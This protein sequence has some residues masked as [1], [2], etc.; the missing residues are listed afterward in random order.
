M[1]MIHSEAMFFEIMYLYAL[2]TD[3]V[4]LELDI[5]KEAFYELQDIITDNIKT[6]NYNFEVELDNLVTRY[7]SVFELTDDTLIIQSDIDQVYVLLDQQ[8]E[9]GFT[10]YDDHLTY[11]VQNIN[12]Y[13]ILDIKDPSAQYKPLWQLNKTILAYHFLLSQKENKGEK[14]NSKD[15]GILMIYENQFRDMIS[16]IS[17][18]DDLFIRAALEFQNEN[19]T[20]NPDWYIALFEDYP[21]QNKSFNHS[22]VAYYLEPYSILIKAEEKELPDNCYACYTDRDYFLSYFIIVLDR[23]LPKLYSNGEINKILNV[24]KHLLIAITPPLEKAYL[25]CGSLNGTLEPLA[26]GKNTKHAFLSFYPAVLERIQTLNSPDIMLDVNK[27]SNMILSAIFIR[28]FLDTCMHED[29]L[30]DVYH[31]IKDAKWFNNPN[32]YYATLFTQTI[33]LSGDEPDI[34]KKR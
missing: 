20:L 4:E 16:N 12:I 9:G 27:I 22:L 18:K 21:L 6:I 3:Y 30:Q 33:I 7:S 24:R 13:H 29:V 28:T 34:P 11:L 15:R 23:L 8:L 26:M 14:I 19:H 25:E 1:F 32:Y 2:F 31:R 5:L 17:G 10:E